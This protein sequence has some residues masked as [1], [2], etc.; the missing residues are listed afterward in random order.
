M[1]EELNELAA[2]TWSQRYRYLVEKISDEKSILDAIEIICDKKVD[3][4]AN[5]RS[6]KQQFVC[7]R[8]LYMFIMYLHFGVKVQRVADKFGMT[9]A[10]IYYHC[11]SVFDQYDVDLEFRIKM[12]ML[13]TKDYMIELRERLS[14]VERKRR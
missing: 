13:F 11:H 3:F 8:R 7:S 1:T 5:I 14:K 2:N 12:S 9:R 6:R 4:M 10:N